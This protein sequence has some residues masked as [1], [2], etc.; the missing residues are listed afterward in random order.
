MDTFVF[1]AVLFA[2]ACHAGWNAAIKRGLDPLTTT[3]LISLGATVAALALAPFTD[4]PAA[5]AWPWAIASVVIHLGYFAALIESYRA[6][7]MGQVY[8]LAR[9]AAPLMT[10]ALS[11]LGVGEAGGGVAFTGSAML[12]AGVILLS[13]PG[14]RELAR[15]DALA[16]GFALLTAGQTCARSPPHGLRRPPSVAG[17][18]RHYQP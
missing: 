3:V 11:P 13:L 9:G 8:P 18:A 14:G 17:P 6:G 2:A 10:A 15:I 5:P 12:A 1:A 16:V 4:W 7:D